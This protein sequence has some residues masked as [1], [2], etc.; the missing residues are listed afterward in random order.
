[1]FNTIAIRTSLTPFRCAAVLAATSLGLLALGADV[2][3]AAP[4]ASPAAPAEAATV[5]GLNLEF[6]GGSVADLVTMVRRGGGISFN[7]IGERADMATVLPAFSLRN[8]DAESLA[9]AV[10]MLLRNQG[11]TVSEAGRRRPFEMAPIYVL[12][13]PPGP[14]GGPPTSWLKCYPLRKLAPG[15]DETAIAA[16]IQAAWAL[17][18][19][20]DPMELRLQFHPGTQLLLVSGSSAACMVADEVMRALSA[21]AP[22]SPA[23]AAPVAKP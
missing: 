6:P 21:P 10:E 18:P 9:E 15:A 11:Y 4:P 17:D 13:R 8:A 16:A 1:M 23:T 12:S 5:P 22:E 14:V 2:V 20:H 3:P 19:Q 7:L